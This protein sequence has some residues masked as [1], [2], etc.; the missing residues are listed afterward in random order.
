MK[1]I[2]TVLVVLFSVVVLFGCKGEDNVLKYV[3]LKVYDPV[4]IAIEKGYFE[5]EGLKV[6]LINTIAGGPTGVQMVASGEV[7]ASLSSYMA[8][9]NSVNAGLPIIGVTDVQSSIIGAPLEEF[10]VK[11]N[12]GINELK[13][14]KGKTIAINLFNSSFH[15]TWLI[16]L[17]EVGLSADDVNFVLLPFDVQLTALENGNVDA[18]G[19]MTPFSAVAKNTEGM[20]MLFSA[21]DVF[22][23]KQFATHFLN[24]TWANKNPKDAE[25]FVAGIVKAINF[26]KDNQAEAKNIIEKYSNID[27]ELIADYYFQEN[28]MVVLED[29]QYWID[30]MKVLDPSIV[31]TSAK[32][33]VTN[34]Y[35][36]LVK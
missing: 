24:K 35:N 14:L 4:Y 5:E 16:A 12:S 11:E 36:K 29:A 27:S 8:I 19:L 6:E 33:I 32:E 9:I 7:D 17:A 3:G 15:Y 2:L 22:G 34:D 13:D 20:K 10:Y 25:K 31:L 1:K 21:L 30:Y 28:G 18:I 23:E 26:S